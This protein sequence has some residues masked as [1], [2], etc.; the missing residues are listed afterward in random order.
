MSTNIVPLR[1]LLP[2]RAIPTENF[3][4]EESSEL[5]D[6]NGDNTLLRMH[7]V[8]QII[9][10][11]SHI[12]FS[13]HDRVLIC[14]SQSFS[15]F[16]VFHHSR[17]FHVYMYYRHCAMCT[18]Q[19]CITSICNFEPLISFSSLTSPTSNYFMEGQEFMA[20]V[21]KSC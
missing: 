16:L 2:L 5:F 7:K 8:F 17:R 11:C 20:V 15:L 6:Y 3:C 4:F 19:T 13:P 18:I 1:T 10:F 14:C 9:F 21:F 12:N